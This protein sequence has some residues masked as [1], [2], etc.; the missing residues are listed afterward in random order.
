[1]GW[2]LKLE[3]WHELSSSSCKLV[4]T[5]CSDPAC[6]QD[7]RRGSTAHSLHHCLSINIGRLNAFQ[8][9]APSVSAKRCKQ[10][11]TTSKATKAAAAAAVADETY[12]V[13]ED[14]EAAVL[15]QPDFSSKADAERTMAD[16]FVKRWWDL[17][18]QVQVCLPVQC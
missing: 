7:L 18:E 10:S 17:R 9:V 14:F 4:Q 8:E 5:P 3:L 16:L 12:T 2:L 13:P 1:M 6:C 15:G 11:K